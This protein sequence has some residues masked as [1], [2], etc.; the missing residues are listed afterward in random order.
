MENRVKLKTVKRIAVLGAVIG[1]VLLWTGV[2]LRE[3]PTVRVGAIDLQYN[4]ALA[5]VEGT[6]LDVTIDEIKDSFRITVDDG[7]GRISLN[8]Y[9]KY[10]RF[11]DAMGESFPRIGDTVAAV[12][13]LSV[14][15]SWGITMFM[16]SPRRM[17]LVERK[18]LETL[19]L[20]GI[21]RKDIGRTGTF[22]ARITD[23]RTFNSGRALTI[24]D[25]SGATELTV[26]DSEL[27]TLAPD[28][29]AAL[30]SPGA[31]IRFT[32]RVDAYRNTLQLR[33]VQPEIPENFAVVEPAGT[34]APGSAAE[35]NAP[36]NALPESD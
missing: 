34:S 10:T 28:E 5:R 13:N 11:K 18:K 20:G 35:G 2:R 19:T 24:E 9:G 17:E 4:M 25:A 15:E 30:E 12:G 31:V 3:I 6:V 14:S 23:I 32:G 36:A 8:G 22:T 16:A 26:F 21:N 7:T 27:E 1:L 33:L 29:T